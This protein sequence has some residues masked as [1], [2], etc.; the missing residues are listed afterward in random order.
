MIGIGRENMSPASSVL[1]FKRL[2]EYPLHL[3]KLSSVGCLILGKVSLKLKADLLEREEA[4][5]GDFSVG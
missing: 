4:L 1:L 5:S 3:E 2:N